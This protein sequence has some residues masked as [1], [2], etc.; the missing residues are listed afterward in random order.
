MD[1]ASLDAKKRESRYQKS[2]RD[3]DA[4]RRRKPQ[5][6]LPPHAVPYFS[7][8]M[9]YA[10]RAKA[11]RR[12][13]RASSARCGSESKHEGRLAVIRSMDTMNRRPMYAEYFAPTWNRGTVMRSL[14]S[15]IGAIVGLGWDHIAGRCAKSFHVRLSRWRCGA[16][17]KP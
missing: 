13:R 11:Q 8:D 2:A 6:E 10:A 15:L 12:R 9:E 5:A 14:R 17:A 16:V 3:V 4:V 1:A 7:E